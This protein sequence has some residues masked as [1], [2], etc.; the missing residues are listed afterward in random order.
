MVKTPSQRSSEM[1]TQAGNRI[2]QS[3]A[4]L[5]S[6]PAAAERLECSEMHIYRLVSSGE[7]RAVD[8]SRK[9]ARKSKTRIRSDDLDAYIE[10][11]TRRAGTPSPTA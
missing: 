3:S 7:L 2:R 1:A 8:I 10:S 9:G 5:L 4:Q 11:R 6:I